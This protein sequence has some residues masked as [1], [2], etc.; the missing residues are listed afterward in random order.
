MSRPPAWRRLMRILGRDPAEETDEELRFHLEMRTRDYLEAGM[1]EDEARR[2]AERRLG[3]VE[4]VRREVGEFEHA[5][6]AEERRREWLSE[7]R[8]D[9]RYGA[10]TLLRA[11]TF[12][13]MTVLTLA[14]GIGATTAIFS[15][16]YAVLL[17]PLPYPQPDRLVRIWETS[18]QGATRNVVSSGNALDWQERARSFSVIGIHGQP[19][20]VPLTGEDDP[21]QVVR[22]VV[23]P[24]VMRALDVTPALGRTFVEEDAVE[25]G[26]A[27]ISHAVWQSRYG[28][29]PGVIER[30]IVLNDATYTIVGVLPPGFAFP[31]EGVEFWIPIRDAALDPEERTSHNYL[32]LARLAAGATVESAQAEMTALAGE[33]AR[34]HPAPMTGW[35]VNVVPLHEDLTRNVEAL[36]RVLL[37]S[38]VVVLL[39]A[40]GNIANLLLARA[41]ARQR[42]VALRGALGAG[43]GRILRQLLTET[44]L[45]TALGG[46]GALVFAP[47]LLRA[48]VSVAPGDIPLLERAVIDGRMLAFAAAAA[49][50]SAVLFGLA[51][52]L[53]LARADLQ[54][55]LRGGQGS[56]AAGHVRLRGGLLVGQ[57]ALSV[58]LLVGAGLFV[59]SF[60]ALQTTELGFDPERLVLMEVNL[61]QARYPDRPEQVG[62]YDALLARARALPT[63][64]DAA[65]TSQPPGSASGMTFSFAIEGRVASNPSGRED[66]ETLHAITPGYFDVVGSRIVGGRGFDERDTEDAL[67]V[68]II[69]E[70][71]ARKHWPEGGALGSRMAFRVGETPW[72]EV[73][74]VVGDARLESPDVEPEPA[75]FIPFAQ[76]TWPWLTWTTVVARTR[77]GAD[78]LAVTSGLR[79]ALLELDP[80]LPPQSLG[81][82][83][84]AFRRNTARRTFAMSLVTGFGVLALVLSVVGLYG[85]VSYSV[86]RQRREI[87]VR[88]ALGAHSGDVV[89][90]VLKSSLGLTLLGA[91]GGVAVAAA[92]SRVIDGL[93]YG[94]SA[95]DAPTYVVTVAVVGLVAL[96]TAALPARR[97]ARTDPIGALKSD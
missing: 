18:P 10:R 88:I 5:R 59:R 1:S 97:A 20:L 16:V 62:F 72:R 50:G 91:A 31:Q 73:V 75:I 83:E 92:A 77:A 78:P 14:L 87:G 25:G 85:L 51:P 11:P 17:A 21:A 60:R 54:S 29:D 74:G 64:I 53:R 66:D 37:G 3:D 30:R 41:V 22:A 12:T 46:T 70:S 24:E 56:S 81:T 86:A 80:A 65:G 94:V 58:L 49:I 33:I 34:E 57:V 13:S 67:P 68:V 95:L 6:W 8:Q 15:L 61:P 42:E 90:R 35:G 47:V 43:R 38:V 76:K 28:G 96:A 32:V 27:L 36:F 7:L 9:L 84:A 48:L 26:V 4:D 69:N 19:F 2:A 23:Q 44:L 40:C 93:L 55:A 79:S 63:V 45:L 71:L 39:I 82:V 52:A 89:G